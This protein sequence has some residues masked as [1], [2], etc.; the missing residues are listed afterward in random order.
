MTF[1]SV[2]NINSSKMK[3][4]LNVDLNSE[5]DKNLVDL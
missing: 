5:S 4:L 2:Y 3:S 1:S